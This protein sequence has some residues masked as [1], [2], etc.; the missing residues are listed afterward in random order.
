[1]HPNTFDGNP[2][3][4]EDP[5]VY[6]TGASQSEGQATDAPKS[7]G[8]YVGRWK[9][10]PST[11]Y[12]SEFVQTLRESGSGRIE[13][14]DSLRELKRRVRKGDLATYPVQIVN[15]PRQIIAL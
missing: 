10:R 9:Y 12:A 3:A 4:I 7:A 5:F 13:T 14:I 15:E 6:V 8:K 1:M 2:R 11:A